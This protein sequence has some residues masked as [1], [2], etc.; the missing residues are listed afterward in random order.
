MNVRPAMNE[1]SSSFEIATISSAQSYLH[2]PIHTSIAPR[3]DFD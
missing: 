1:K 2:R 3:A